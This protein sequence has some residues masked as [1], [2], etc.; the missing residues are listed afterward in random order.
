MICANN[1]NMRA[2]PCIQRK[3]H[4]IVLVLEIGNQ[5]TFLAPLLLAGEW[6]RCQSYHQHPSHRPAACRPAG[7]CLLPFQLNCLNTSRDCP[8]SSSIVQTLAVANNKRLNNRLWSFFCLGLAF[9]SIPF[10]LPVKLIALHHCL[11]P[12]PN[13]LHQHR[14][15]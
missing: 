12:E 8:S 11:F 13:A 14:S 4:L 6:N 3:I 10:P 7:E 5:S 15:R 9:F 2:P 1:L